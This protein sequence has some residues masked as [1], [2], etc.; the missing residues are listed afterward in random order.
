VECTR[1]NVP[2]KFSRNRDGSRLQEVLKLAVATLGA[3]V[4]PAVPLQHSNQI[5]HLHVPTLPL[6]PRPATRESYVIRSKRRLTVEL[7][8]AHAGVW[9]WHFIFHASAP[10]SC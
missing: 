6:A 8:G 4:M 7:S 9:A 3:D 1:R 2:A 5:P 10:T